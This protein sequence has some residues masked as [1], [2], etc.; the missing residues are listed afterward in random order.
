MHFGEIFGYRNNP[1]GMWLR[2]RLRLG[3]AWGCK[4]PRTTLFASV[5][6]EIF[7][8]ARIVHIIRDGRD[9]ALSLDKRGWSRPLP[10][11]KG[12]SL[13]AA[14]IYWEWIVRKGRKYGA[15]LGSNY[16]EVRYEELV[17]DP[18]ESLAHEDQ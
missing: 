8:D 15:M 4:E 10:W 7:P 13:L 16:M 17:S 5:R 18:G 14:G 9:V 1:N 2:L 3:T 11:D 6:L 12:K